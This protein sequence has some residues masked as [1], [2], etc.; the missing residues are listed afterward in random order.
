[1]LRSVCQWSAVLA[2]L[3]ASPAVLAQDPAPQP[4]APADGQ[5]MAALRDAAAGGK[6][7]F[8]FFWRQQDAATDAMWKTF[9]GAMPRLVQSADA[10]AVRV[11][12][13][14]EKAVVEKFGV[15]RSPMPLV[16]A[17]APC[18]AVTKALPLKCDEAQLRQAFVTPCT[19]RCLKGLQDRKLVLLCAQTVAGQD[20][21]WLLPQG[22]ADL[23]ADPQYA[24]AT[25]VV[26]LN[27][28]EQAEARL[29]QELQID[30]RKSPF[31]T[32]LFA[33]PGTLV[34]KFEGAVT[35]EQIVARL[36]SSQSGSCPG[37]QCGPG[38]CGPKR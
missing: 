37:G 17:V 4:P 11:G 7:L 8:I 20:G 27:M 15:E 12:D 2:L 6:Y 38:G 34:G 28:A 3:A 33:P 13:P 36:A 16:L 23:R 24:Q 5:G 22:V 18:G 29:L 14:A 35:K 32:V 30:P 19:E 26:L 25:E 9:S 31:V 21:R 1:M 10:A